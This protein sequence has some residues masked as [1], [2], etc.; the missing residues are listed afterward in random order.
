MFA[1][2]ACFVTM[3]ALIKTLGRGLPITE[4]MFLRSLIALPVL[5]GLLLHGGHPLIVHDWKRLL[6]RMVFGT[7]AMFCFYYALTHMPL[8]DCVFIGRTQPL[9]LTLL[10]PFLVGEQGKKN[11]WIAISLGLAG[12]AMI[13]RPQVDW[14]L[15]STAALTAAFL[16][17]LAHLMVRR[18]SRT[19]VTPVIV[20]NFTF[21]L[22]LISG[23]ATLSTFILPSSRQWLLLF[24]IAGFASLGQY[25]LTKAYSLDHA[26]TVAAASYAS[27]VLSV[28]YGY[29][30][31]NEM[32]SL[33]SILGAL[34]IVSGGIYLMLTTFRAEYPSSS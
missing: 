18:L 16:A 25:L 5:F 34:L 17:A 28:I 2:S 14:T 30:F 31:W 29:L 7:T 15:A 11:V 27:V 32:P 23:L 19:D 26:P 4:L 3:A 22:C 12:T 9:F 24:A 10:A 13:M 33:S 6:L 8:A 20:F 1:A 21:L